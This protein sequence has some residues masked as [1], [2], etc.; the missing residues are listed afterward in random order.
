MKIELLLLTTL[1]AAALAAPQRT[2]AEA[3][4]ISQDNNIEPDGNYQ[5]SYET[6]NGIRGQEQGTLKQSSSPDTSDVIIASGS[7]SY[8]S[9]EGVVITLNYAADDENGFQAQGE[10]LPTPPPIPPQI[11]RALDYLAQFAPNN[12]RR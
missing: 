12:R 10:H 7:Y 3:E 8:T 1:V 9:P 2:E 4:I 11:Q 5:Y 6:A